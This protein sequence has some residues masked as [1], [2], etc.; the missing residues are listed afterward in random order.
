MESEN[1]KNDQIFSCMK[2][3]SFSICRKFT[4]SEFFSQLED[5]IDLINNCEIQIF[6]KHFRKNLDGYKKDLKE[7]SKD[8]FFEI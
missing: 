6:H 2:R 7:F 8:I 5:L 1:F 4:L 3:I